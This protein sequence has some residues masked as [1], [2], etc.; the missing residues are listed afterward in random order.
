MIRNVILHLHGELPLKADIESLPTAADAGL[1]CTN[2]RTIEGRKPLSTEFLDSVF[3]VPYNII[4]FI[5]IPRASIDQAGLGMDLPIRPAQLTGRSKRCRRSIH[6]SSSRRRRAA[7]SPGGQ[8]RKTRPWSTSSRTPSC[9]GASARPESPGR[10]ARVVRRG[11]GATLAGHDQEP[12]D[13]RVTR[14]GADDRAIPG[15]W[16]QGAGLVRSCARPAGEPRQGQAGRGRRARLRAR[17]RHQRGP[18]QA[19]RRH[20]PGGGRRRTSST[21]PPTSTAKARPSP[22][23]SWRPWT[24]RRQARRVTFSEITKSAIDAAFA[25]PRDIDMDL[26]DAQ[27]TRRIMDR[28]VG[29]TLSPL[30]SRKVRSGLSAGRVQSVA[31][32]LVVERERAHRGLHGARVLDAGGQPAH[33][34]RRAL[35]GQPHPRGRHVRGPRA[36]RWAA[37]EVPIADEATA[38]A[39]V[40]E[41]RGQ[42]ATVTSQ[43]VR[44][45]KR[46]PA[47][48]F[49]TSTL[50]QEASRK[51]GFGPRRTM[52]VAQRLYEG[53]VIDGE[54]TG[55]ITYMRTDSVNLATS[56][57]HEAHD[58]I[59]ERFGAE[60]AVKGG[61][62]LSQPHQGRPGGPR[63]HPPHEL[64]ARPG[65]A[66]GPHQG[67]GAAALPAHLAACPG[68]ADGTQ[69]SWR[70]PPRSWRPAASGC[71]PAPRA[72]S[73]TA[74]RG[75]TRRAATTRPTTRRRAACRPSRRVTRPRVEDVAAEQHFTEPPPRFTEA[76]LIKAL[77]EHGIGRPS[78]YAATISTIQERGYVKVEDRRL[79]PEVVAG[80]VTDVLVEHFGDYVDVAFTARME[81]SST[82]W[83]VA[84]AGGCRSCASSTIP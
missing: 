74:S 49:T 10:R 7:S 47:P 3:L 41:L 31:V 4:R 48:P 21:S 23:T 68:L 2:L 66:E 83:P 30:I 78:T 77:E 32:R 24:S 6:R 54:P 12:G 81:E 33:A 60:Y 84:S 17:V 65:L 16:L 40:E 39:Y 58:V 29:Y 35:H 26:V 70:R 51:L 15:R 73:S 27:Q 79:R 38:S 62:R 69:G 72:R 11:T 45:S 63:G 53:I 71:G 42:A 43:S 20:Q 5:E 9:S 50:Q 56:A 22:G 67:R 34:A 28:L 76:T 18:P 64:P 14:Q 46:N 61:S 82:R 1:L 75:S 37:G 36:A 55:L 59:G 44:G 19:A 13:R 80:I 57:Q 25:H 52:S 8:P